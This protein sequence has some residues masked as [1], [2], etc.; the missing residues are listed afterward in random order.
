MKESDHNQHIFKETKLIF[1]C[2]V[3]ELWELLLF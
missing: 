3:T 2:K 1:V